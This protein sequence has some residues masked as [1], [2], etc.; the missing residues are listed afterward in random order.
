MEKNF[1]PLVKIPSLWGGDF[2]GMWIYRAMPVFLCF[3]SA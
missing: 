1:F 3:A 2:Q